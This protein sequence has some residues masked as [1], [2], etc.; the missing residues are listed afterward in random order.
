MTHSGPDTL[1]VTAAACNYVPQLRVLGESFTRHHPGRRIT[2]LVTD[3][4][5]GEVDPRKEPYDVLFPGD[6][7]L[8]RDWVMTHTRKE[9]SAAAKAHLLLHALR[10]GQ[11]A[12]IFVDPDTLV[13][14]RMQDVEI[15]VRRHPL[16][17]RPHLL[18][19]GPRSDPLRAFVEDRVLE[20][21]IYNGGLIG[22]SDTSDARAFLQWWADRQTDGCHHDLSQG[23]HFDQRWLDLAPSLLHGIAQFQDAGLDVAF[24]S[25]PGSTLS[26]ADGTLRIDGDPVRLIH[27]TGFVAEHPDVMVAYFKDLFRTADVPTLVPHYRR[28]TEDLVRA[29]RAY[30]RARRYGF[31]HF[32]DQSPVSD[33]ARRIYAGM[34]DAWDRFGDP[35]RTGPGSFHEW[36]TSSADTGF[37]VITREW[38]GRHA[39]SPALRVS[40]PDPLG[41]DRASFHAWTQSPEALHS[42]V[43]PYITDG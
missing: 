14:G 19:A 10:S 30:W 29:G 9:L 23:E 40:F 33:V 39:R 18:G 21:G 11:R 41:A 3:R 37:P 28:Y 43:E 26:D 27:F 7:G 34:D 31:G 6:V 20:A 2:A 38:I 22:V 17:L 24:W 16:T 1:W 42:R 36:L 8:P 12:A 15:R 32:D 13:L 4:W 5:P 35:F 25:L